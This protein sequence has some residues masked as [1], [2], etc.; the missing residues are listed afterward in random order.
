MQLRRARFL[1]T[2]STTQFRDR[3]QTH[4]LVRI[5][6]LFERVVIEVQPGQLA[7]SSA[8]SDHTEYFTIQAA[9]RGA[10]GH[11]HKLWLDVRR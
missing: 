1:S 2:S 6:C 4:R 8:R 3:T 7:N 5:L 10:Q 11:F 9:V